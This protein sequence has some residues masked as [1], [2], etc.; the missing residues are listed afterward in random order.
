MCEQMSNLEALRRGMVR[1]GPRAGWR[2][3]IGARVAEVEPGHAVVELDVHVITQIADA[4]MGMALTTRQEDG[5]SNP[6][7]A[8]LLPDGEVHFSF[9]LETSFISPGRIGEPLRAVGTVL[10]SGRRTGVAE[11]RVTGEADR[12]VAAA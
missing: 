6:T 1:G 2:E 9:D 12:L 11:C 4:A 7:M 8:S 10:H 5:M 3:T